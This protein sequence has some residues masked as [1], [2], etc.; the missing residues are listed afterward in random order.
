[1]QMFSSIS[2]SALILFGSIS[3]GFSQ[4]TLLSVGHINNGGIA[5]DLAVSGHYVYLANLPDGLRIYDVSD[6]GNP[7]NIYHTN[8]AGGDSADVFVSGHYAYLAN[9]PDGLRIYDISNPSNTVQVAHFNTNGYTP[10]S[11]TVTNGYAYVATGSDFEIVN[12]T[13]PSAPSLVTGRVLQS[14][15][16]QLDVSGNYIF[17]AGQAQGLI[18]YDAS[19]LASPVMVGQLNNKG[20]ANW[21]TISGSY[22]YVANGTDGLRVDSI[23]NPASPVNVGHV[24][25]GGNTWGVAV[26]NQYAFVAQSSGIA[27]VDVSDPAQPVSVGSATTSVQAFGLGVSGD[28]IYVANSTDGLRIFRLIPQLQIALNPTQ[29]VSLTW[30][31]TAA[32]F[33]LEQN[34][35]IGTTNWPAVTNTP[36]VKGQKYQILLPRTAASQFFR[37]REQ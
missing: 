2:I 20:S 4:F 21:V 23:T 18:V 6:P 19:N 24:L 13:N 8:N 31:I 32:H 28:F 7:V 14:D 11:V 26:A 9:L 33:E 36:V 15:M 27:V 17:L 25:T 34:A 30:P 22:A 29:S 37:L 16:P 5:S 1:M 3:V 12:V 35:D 10:T